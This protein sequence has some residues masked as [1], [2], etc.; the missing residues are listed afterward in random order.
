MDVDELAGDSRKQQKQGSDN[1]N[2]VVGG[3]DGGDHD[4]G[5]DRHDDMES[6]QSSLSSS[7]SMDEGEEDENKA[8][9]GR[10]RQGSS[11]TSSAQR[12]TIG[13]ESHSDSDS[14]FDSAMDSHVN[15]ESESDHEPESRPDT[16]RP[17]PVPT[18]RLDAIDAATTA[19]SS[20]ASRRMSAHLTR[21]QSH[22]A[23]DHPRS[24]D[25][26]QSRGHGQSLVDRTHG[27][28]GDQ[29]MDHLHD[30][31]TLAEVAQQMPRQKIR[32][33][34]GSVLHDDSTATASESEGSLALEGIDSAREWPSMSDPPRP[35]KDYRQ[36]TGHS[37]LSEIKPSSAHHHHHH[38]QHHPQHQNHHQRQSASYTGPAGSNLAMTRPARV[39]EDIT[40]DSTPRKWI[41]KQVP[42]KTLGGEMMMPIWFS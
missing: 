31:S 8:I 13:M 22:N 20:N 14:Q 6:D 4:R 1:C 39:K 28:R 11:P 40:K 19:T 17:R 30:L 5:G 2:T 12:H 34:G 38:R 7:S 9:K 23:T 24:M 27:G 10:A 35:P 32:A 26:N 42:V 18:H 33:E 29:A 36:S 15:S 21:R 37:R 25:M 3:S 16:H 41:C